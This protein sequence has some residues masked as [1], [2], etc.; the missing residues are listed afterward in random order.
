MK[1]AMEVL[2]NLKPQKVS[3]S[4]PKYEVE[5]MV[6]EACAPR[7]ANICKKKADEREHGPPHLFKRLKKAL[8]GKNEETGAEASQ[9]ED[10]A[11]VEEDDLVFGQDILM[12]TEGFD[13]YAQ[14]SSKMK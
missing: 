14:C 12:K 13:F 11:V 10:E 8:S 5:L 4:F 6:R 3:F 1:E 7:Q 9:K 2:L